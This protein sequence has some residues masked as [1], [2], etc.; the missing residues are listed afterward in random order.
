MAQPSTVTQRQSLSIVR[1]ARHRVQNLLANPN[2]QRLAMALVNCVQHHIEQRG[3]ARA[4][5]P[6]TV[7]FVQ[8][9]GQV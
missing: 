3:A 7:N 4:S 6:I 2:R 8:G 1:E 5:E 9:R